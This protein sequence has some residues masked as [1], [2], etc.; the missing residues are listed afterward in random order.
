[1]AGESESPR[2][3]AVAWGRLQVEGRSAPFKDAKLYPGGAREWDW[4]ETGTSHSPGVAPGDVAELC[5]R[6]AEVVVVGCGM[7]ERLQVRADALALA[8]ERGAVVEVLQTERAVARYNA[9]RGT[10]RVG[11]LIHT[12]C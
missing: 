8:R 4:S 12:T 11:G 5:D 3:A 6:G 7:N 10:R 1:M 9:L 2:I